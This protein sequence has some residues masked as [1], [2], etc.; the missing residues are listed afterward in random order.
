VPVTVVTDTTHYLPPAIVAAKGL[1]EISLYV[2]FQGRQT[3]ESEI[4]LDTDTFYDAMRS[5]ADL[6]TTSQPSIG[7][8][9][10]VWEPLLNDGQD[11]VSIHLA[12][13][14]SGTYD[15]ALQAKARL[16]DDGLDDGRLAVV[17]S[18]TGC[19]GMGLVLLAAA[20]CAQADGDV[21]AVAQKARAAREALG[22]WFAVDTLEYLRRG[23]RIGGAAALLG[24]A[25]KIKPI[26][27]FTEEI[28]PLERVRTS[29][30]A[31]DRL[32]AYL[33]SHKAAGADAFVVQ[34]VQAPDV[35]ERI[36]A[37]AR[38]IF[39]TDPIFLSE[40]GPVIGAHVGP[41]LIGVGALPRTMLL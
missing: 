2:T 23:G 16:V 18:R 20:A 22:M 38:E 11:I 28:T 4:M 21:E 6:P 33:E 41:G 15:S 30:R 8:F 27:T 5:A 3:R 1:Q 14:V 24:S 35:A 19:G 34:H 29:A 31:L 25:L 9:L 39:G 32:V 12:S 40:I 17:D 26:L 13:G 10:A 36:A 7:D 37:R